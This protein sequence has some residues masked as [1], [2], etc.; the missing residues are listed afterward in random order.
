MFRPLMAMLATMGG[1]RTT[2]SPVLKVVEPPRLDQVGPAASMVSVL[3]PSFS[4]SAGIDQAVVPA[5]LPPPPRL[6]VHVTLI[7]LVPRFVATPV[8]ARMS[9]AVAT[10]AGPAGVS[11]VTRGGK[12]EGWPSLCA[13]TQ[14]TSGGV[15]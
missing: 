8:S 5:A 10:G 15:A 14:S 13:I 3:V 11:N 6:L 7:I 4:G 9:A 12:L 2:V 1:A